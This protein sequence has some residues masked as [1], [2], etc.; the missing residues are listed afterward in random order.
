MLPNGQNPRRLHLWAADLFLHNPTTNTWTEAATKQDGDRSDEESWVKP[1]PTEAFSLYSIFSSIATGVSRSAQK[2]IPLYESVG[3]A[4]NPSPTSSGNPLQ[5]SSDSAGDE[6]GPALALARWPGDS[7]WLDRKP[8]PSTTTRP[9]PGRGRYP[10][11]FDRFGRSWRSAAHWN[12]ADCRFALRHPTPW[13]NF[14]FPPPT[15]IY[16]FNPTT[17]VYTDVTPTRRQSRSRKRLLDDH[18]RS[19][20]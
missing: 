9:I 18:A 19:A 10:E 20:A 3:Q 1:F 11:Q 15:N 14:A 7:V 17:G 8:R 6:L 16:E 2:Y 4:G 13:G 5:L 12:C